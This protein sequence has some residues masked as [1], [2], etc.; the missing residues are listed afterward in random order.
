MSRKSSSVTIRDVAQKAGVSV[1]TVS[2]YINRSVPVSPEVAER[3]RM[4]MEELNYVPHVTAR[5]LAT[6]RAHAIGV[7]LEDMNHEFFPPLIAGI[8]SIVQQ[9]GYNL[10]VASRRARDRIDAQIPIGPHNSDGMIVFSSS[11]NNSE[12][13][14][15]HQAGFPLVLIYR[16]APEGTNIPSVT[17]RNKGS[18]RKLIDHLIEVHH[19]SRIVFVRGPA[20][21]E[22]SQWREKGYQESLAAHGIAYDPNLLISGGYNRDVA[23]QAMSKFLANEHP[24]F[25][26]VFTGNDDSA[27]SVMGALKE[28]GLSIPDDISVV[29]FDDLELSTFLTPP[30]TTVN[31]PTECVGKTAAQHLFKLL[32]GQKVDPV[33]LLPTEIVIRRSCGCSA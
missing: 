15:L 2:R 16:A 17:V 21:N 22:D 11:L 25:D 4:V 13:L 1:A 20:N 6:Q 3:I 30:L 23:Y 32:A 24:D 28:K 31:A 18:T 19:C 7:L 27:V 8:E 9:E 29:G 12:I 14:K 33:T 26:A 5:R 10:L